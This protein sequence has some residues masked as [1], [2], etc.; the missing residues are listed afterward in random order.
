MAN[1]H[2][3]E[4]VLASRRW[5]RRAAPFPHVVAFDVLRPPVYEA[6][7]EGF[8]ELLGVNGGGYLSGHDIHGSTLTPAYRGPLE[9]FISRPWH[10]LLAGLMRV[11]A[12][13]H[14]NCGIHHHATGS[15]NGFPHNDL[16]PGWFVD[17]PA[18][19]GIR[20]ADPAACEYTTGRLHATTDYPLRRTVRA[21]A[22]IFYLANLP[23]S[24]GDG[25]T[26]GLYRNASDPVER[27]VAVVPPIN[28]SMLVFE[29]TPFS[30]HGFIGNRV[31][32]RNSVVL[33]LHR[34]PDDVIRRW[35][36]Q[37]IVDYGRHG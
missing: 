36:P 5:W 20:V 19:D 7:C 23:W 16:N 14:V 18:A 27:P 34:S 3:I 29:C 31:H 15:A 2:D 6:V 22:A 35:G 21:V 24:R 12:T 1:G 17:Y 26:T 28:N 13:G 10:Q 33:W 25:G 30:F 8:S 37:A 4:A 9:L 32:P 11:D